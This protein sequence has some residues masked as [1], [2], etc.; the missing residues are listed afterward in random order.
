[1]RSGWVVMGRKERAE[2]MG[3]TKRIDGEE[4]RRKKREG[5]R[6]IGREA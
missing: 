2:E 5:G 1:M 4:R 6:K 3:R